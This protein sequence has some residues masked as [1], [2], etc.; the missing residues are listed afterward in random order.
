MNRLDEAFARLKVNQEL[1][2]FPYLMTGYDKKSLTL[3]HDSTAVV[4]RTLSLS[5]M[6]F[7][8]LTLLYLC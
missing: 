6:N 5:G 8:R 1:G 4:V 7:N 2:L 3:S